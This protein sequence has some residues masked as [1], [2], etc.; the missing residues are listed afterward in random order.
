[1]VDINT[2]SYLPETATFHTQIPQLEDG[3]W[4]TGG[5]VDPANDS[6]IMNWQALLLGDRTA[7]LLA[8]IVALQTAMG[9]IDVSAQINAAIAALINGAP[10]ALDTLNELA[11]AIGDNDNELATLLAQISALS[12][13]VAALAN[14]NAY[15]SGPLTFSNGAGFTLAHG[16][17]VAPRRIRF[18]LECVTADAGYV[19]GDMVDY[20]ASPI[21]VTYTSNAGLAVVFNNTNIT[22]RVS[23]TSNGLSF[24]RK[25]NGQQIFLNFSR[26]KLHVEAYA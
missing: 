15:E 9:N 4:P 17:G 3:F 2:M 22:L 7:Y 18:L 19:V 8:Q 12:A 24:L 5:V 14:P 26:W 20:S 25:D 21:H 13:Q 11:A 6:G 16:L 1:M 23:N 10:G